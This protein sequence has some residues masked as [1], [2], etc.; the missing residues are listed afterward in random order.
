MPSH[1][2][3][4]AIHYIDCGESPNL[5]AYKLIW[6]SLTFLVYVM[7]FFAMKQPEIFKI[8]VSFKKYKGSALSEDDIR[9]IGTDLDRLMQA[10]KPY[11]NPKLTK[12][13]LAVLTETNTSNLSRIINEGFGKNFFDFV[14]AYRVQEFIRLVRDE[15]H[16]NYIL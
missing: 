9:R 14:N 11:L 5:Q 4:C 7:G 6:V 8:S 13:E 2:D 10:D 1:L 12:A 16:S 3:I 15:N